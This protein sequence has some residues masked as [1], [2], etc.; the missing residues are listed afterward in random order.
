MSSLD[1][2]LSNTPLLTEKI[3]NNEIYAQ[4]MYAALCNNE[5]I[6]KGDKKRWYCS[7]RRA[8]GIIAEIR[9]AH[10]SYM[11]WYC[12]GMFITPG[13]VAESVITSE[14][15]LDLLNINWLIKGRS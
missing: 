11:D 5:F 1:E 6:K 15:G 13:Y 3:K 12:S 8:G 14:I 4:N 9:G 7:W 10:E 2:D